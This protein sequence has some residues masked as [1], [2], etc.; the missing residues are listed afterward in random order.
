MLARGEVEYH[1]RATAGP[2]S[3]FSFGPPTAEKRA[4]FSSLPKGGD[5]HT[6]RQLVLDELYGW[7]DDSATFTTAYG[8]SWT[9]DVRE[10]MSRHPEVEVANVALNPDTVSM[11]LVPYAIDEANFGLLRLECSGRGWFS[12]ETIEAYEA[13]AETIGLA[14]SQRRG[15]A[16][17][18]ER[19]KELSCLYGLARAIESAGQDVN[20]ALDQITSL[21]PPAWQYPEVAISRIVFDGCV[22]GAAESV[23]TEVLQ[24]ADILVEGIVRGRVEVGYIQTVKNALSG[25]FLEE[26]AHLIHA[27]AREVGDYIE[28]CEAA[29]GSRQ[30]EEQLHHADRLATLGKLV[31]G[32]AHEINEP[33]SSILGFAQLAHK[34]SDVDSARQDLGRII[35]SCLQA[36][37]IVNKL[38]LF[39]R[40]TPIDKSWISI[41]EIVAESLTFVRGRCA[42]QGIEV[43]H[44]TVDEAHM[45]Q[46]DP[47]QLKQVLVNLAVNAVQSMPDGGRLIVT[48]R[49]MED[50][51][52]VEVSDTGIGMTE[53]V[54]QRVFN[55]FFT[56]KDVGEGTGL[57][58]SVVHGI[59]DAH[60][61]EVLVESV[62]HE[63]SK[64]TVRLPVQETAHGEGR[65][66]AQ[67]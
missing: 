59:I 61:G 28:R 30:L 52:T 32:V 36:R 48:T 53:E 55:P 26:E 38:K 64:F 67:T 2:E 18:R 47:V 9:D 51:V 25:P 45:V 37:E 42:S 66:H 10:S 44:V 11:A 34:G 35:G 56:T 43:E 46:A 41:D 4:S 17:L 22:H 31:A 62:L 8:S 16:A 19:V 33:L 40:Q 54:A 23:P 12:S 57:G 15:Q 21:L 1:V 5:G 20:L 29:A 50:T 58:L 3:E 27:V 60:G 14:I 39:A 63:G 65:E 7:I 6:L 49:A 13:V 24:S